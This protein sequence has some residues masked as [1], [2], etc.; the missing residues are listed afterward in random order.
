MLV[1]SMSFG[2]SDSSESFDGKMAGSM[3]VVIC[4]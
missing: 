3:K 1:L 2:V 4:I